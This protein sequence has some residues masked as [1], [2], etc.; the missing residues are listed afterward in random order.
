M[1]MSTTAAEAL[2]STVVGSR[3][4]P[5]SSVMAL[6]D[7][8]AKEF[9]QWLA[10]PSFLSQRLMAEAKESRREDWERCE[11]GLREAEARYANSEA[12]ADIEV[13]ERLFLSREKEAANTEAFLKLFDE[14]ERSKKGKRYLTLEKKERAKLRL[15]ELR[16][17]RE[18]RLMELE[19]LRKK[20]PEYVRLEEARRAHTALSEALGLPELEKSRSQETL[21]LGRMSQNL[22][23]NFERTYFETLEK[24][25]EKDFFRGQKEDCRVLTGVTLG[26]AKAELDSVVV[27]VQEDR[28]VDVLRISEVKR[29]P[30]DVGYAV[31]R[32][33]ETIGFLCG[34]RDNYDPNDWR[35]KTQPNGHFENAVYHDGLRFSPESFDNLREEWQTQKNEHHDFTLPPRF[36]VVTRFANIHNIP[37]KALAKLKKTVAQTPRPNDDFWAKLFDDL[38]L[39]LTDPDAFKA[40]LLFKHQAPDR[41]HLLNNNYDD[42]RKTDTK[43]TTNNPR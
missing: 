30:N 39:D 6:R 28:V 42:T 22:G 29:N 40:I 27:C 31:R 4:L 38:L 13:V 24:N 34:F 5:T 16:S 33:Y 12:R 25:Y 43:E 35:T 10:E 14:E 26:L 41:L 7:F 15:E 17:S 3:E 21:R 36:H 9:C 11:W 1:A 23:R 32:Y 8:V 37:S 18:E 2:L 19:K 20:H